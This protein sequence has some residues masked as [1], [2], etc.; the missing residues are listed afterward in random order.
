M[1]PTK[2]YKFAAATVMTTVAAA[3][4]ITFT[5]SDQAGSSP[6]AAALPR[7]PAAGGAAPSVGINEDLPE[8]STIPSPAESIS[9][10]PSPSTEPRPVVRPRDQR[11]RSEA[12]AEGAVAVPLADPQRR[13]RRRS[14]ATCSAAAA[15]LSAARRGSS[16]PADR[17][18]AAVRAAATESRSPESALSTIRCDATTRPGCSLACSVS[19]AASLTG[20]PITVYSNRWVEPMLPAIT[21]PCETPIP[22]SSSGTSSLSR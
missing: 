16:A 10:S 13:T 5:N 14:S 4:V 19:R 12:Q 7:V 2:V 22:A 9:P 20:S 15:E 8:P 3:T 21:R 11:A 17:A 1:Q 6:V 18:T